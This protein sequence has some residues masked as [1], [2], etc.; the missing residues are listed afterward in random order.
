MGQT[1]VLDAEEFPHIKQ[2][3]THF[4]TVYGIANMY[5]V[6]RLAISEG[7]VYHPFNQCFIS[8]FPTR[9]S[10]NHSGQPS[11]TNQDKDQGE[12]GVVCGFIYSG[13]WSQRV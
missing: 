6:C 10:F 1:G 5:T 4:M 11:V 13:K 7:R 3:F 8:F 12:K 9:A 2:E